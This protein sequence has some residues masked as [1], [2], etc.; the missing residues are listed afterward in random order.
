M[1]RAFSYPNKGTC[2]KETHFVLSD[3][4]II[5]SIEVVGGCN[6]NLKGICRLVVGQKAE[7]V[8]ARIEGTTCGPRPTSCPDQIAQNLKKALAE[9]GQ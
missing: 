2:S 8:I 5:E 6:G 7:D 4:H 9:M 3:D 1:S